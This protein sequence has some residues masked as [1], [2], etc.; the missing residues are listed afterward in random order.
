MKPY[1]MEKKQRLQTSALRLFLEKGITETSVNDIVKD[2]QLAKG[3]FYVYYKDKSALIHEVMEKKLITLM[4]TLILQA[5][6]EHEQC[7]VTWPCAFIK[8]VIGFFGANPHVLKLMHHSFLLEE[9]PLFSL[10]FME[11]SIPCFHEFIVSLQ[12]PK[13]DAR[14]AFKRFTMLVE[15]CAIV[16]F[17]AI[18]YHQPD[19]FE[20][21]SDMF[22]TMITHS[23]VS[24][25]GGSL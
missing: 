19:A 13:E 23:L 25:K 10:T 15:I 2:A 9:K 7:G 11:Q 24:E 14:E 12:M 16:C 21:I 1:Q 18:F 3:T 20:N 22:Y 4:E 6:A 8:Q 5:K 17:N